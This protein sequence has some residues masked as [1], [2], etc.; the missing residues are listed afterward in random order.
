MNFADPHLNSLLDAW[1]TSTDLRTRAEAHNIAFEERLDRIRLDALVRSIHGP[2]SEYRDLKRHLFDFVTTNVEVAVPH[3]PPT[4]RTGNSGASMTQPSPEQ[5]L[6][7]L[8]NVTRH[9]ANAGRTLADLERSHASADPAER[10]VLEDFLDQWNLARDNRP[11]FAAIKDEL[12]SEFG[13]AAW[14]DKL[15][16]RLGLADYTIA[17]GPLFVAL[18]EYTVEEVLTEASRSPDIAYPFC[19]PTFLDSR[20]RSQFFPTP[21]EL[22]AGAPMALFEIWSDDELIA[23]VVH[24]RL[25]YRPHHIAKLGEITSDGPTADFRTVR[26]NHL[27]ALQSATVRDDFGEEL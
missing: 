23:E 26:N 13:D 17:G 20:P 6:V 24:S 18:M 3:V 4:F 9:I 19:V 11:T 7:R 14:P 27:A 21:K 12:R 25:T 1:A 15:R 2:C 10:A 5:K 16:D 8:E 22:P